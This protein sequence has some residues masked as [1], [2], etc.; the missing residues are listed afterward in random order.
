MHE[1]DSSSIQQFKACFGFSPNNW[2]S[3]YLIQS[4]IFCSVIEATTVMHSNNVKI[5]FIG[6]F[7]LFKIIIIINALSNLLYYLF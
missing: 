1:F 6:S 7:V 4:S 2:H 3:F 5:I